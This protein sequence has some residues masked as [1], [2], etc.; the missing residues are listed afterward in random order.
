MDAHIATH[1]DADIDVD[2]AAQTVTAFYHS[3]EADVWGVPARLPLRRFDVLKQ[4][5]SVQH[6][7]PQRPLK[8]HAVTMVWRIIAAMRGRWW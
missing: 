3:H 5:K 7:A 8:V 1:I 6:G 4:L 2:I